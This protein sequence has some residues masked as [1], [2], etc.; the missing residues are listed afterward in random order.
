[1]TRLSARGYTQI[2]H[3]LVQLPDRDLP[4]PST[5]ATMMSTRKHRALLL[6]ILL[7][8]CWPWLEKQWTPLQASVWIRALTAKGAPT[9]SASTLSRAWADLIE[10][11]LVEKDRENRLIRIVPRRED[12]G[13][14]YEPPGG[15]RDR[16][17]AYFALP[18]AFWKKEIFAQLSLPGLVMLLV[19]AKETSNQDEFWLTYENAEPWYGIKPKS[20]QNGLDELRQLGLVH[21]RRQKIKAPLSPLGHTIRTYYSLT[22]DFGHQSRKALQKRA[23]KAF[24]KRQK[25]RPAPAPASNPTP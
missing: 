8:T 17:N 9:W 2:R 3:I 22:G 25:N 12:G 23:A 18:D 7:L 1:M 11:G 20:A 15:R 13:G 24:H 6:Y 10:L 14:A 4:R 21:R 19:V 5:I 16:W